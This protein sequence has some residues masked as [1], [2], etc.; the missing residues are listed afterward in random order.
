MEGR[1][2]EPLASRSDANAH[3]A[4]EARSAPKR[5]RGVDF[6]PLLAAAMAADQSAARE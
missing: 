6:I 4:A 3:V 1:E 2:P 5:M